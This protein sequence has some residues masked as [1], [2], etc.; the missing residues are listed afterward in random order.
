MTRYLHNYYCFFKFISYHHIERQIK[1]LNIFFCF[2]A[3]KLV[4]KPATKLQ[5][6]VVR[7]L[8]T[9][10]KMPMYMGFDQPMTHDLMWSIVREIEAK[11]FRVWGATFDLGNKKF[12]SEFGLYTG[13]YRVKNPFAPDRWFYYNPD[14]PHLQKSFREHCLYKT[15]I[16]PKDPYSKVFGKP[17]GSTCCWAAGTM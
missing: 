15:Y 2:K 12:Q 17:S 13:T 11:G 3:H 4:Y 5:L 9:K 16:I 14:P 6:M 10:W 1:I 7:G 8:I